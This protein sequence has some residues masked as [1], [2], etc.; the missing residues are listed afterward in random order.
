VLP[1]S[2]EYYPLRPN[3]QHDTSVVR[4]AT[5]GVKFEVSCWRETDATMLNA[6]DVA[7]GNEGDAGD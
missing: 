1:A 2:A 4:W 7:A 6:D 5:N 3:G